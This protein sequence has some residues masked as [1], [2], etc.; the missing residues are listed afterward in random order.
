MSKNS[1]NQLVKPMSVSIGLQIIYS[2]TADDPTM[3]G[4]PTRHCM[5]IDG[6][7]MKVLFKLT[8]DE[9]LAFY[10]ILDCPDEVLKDFIIYDSDK[11]K[12]RMKNYM[13][14]HLES[15]F[16]SQSNTLGVTIDVSE[17][18]EKMIHLAEEKIYQLRKRYPEE[19]EVMFGTST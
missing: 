18:A 8:A 5:I 1:T 16:E 14:K 13:I 6:I 10:A 17:C 2:N 4:K 7:S 11:V 12:N 19:T 9:N 3:K 15:F